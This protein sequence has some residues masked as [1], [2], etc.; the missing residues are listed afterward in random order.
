MDQARTVP[1]RRRAMYQVP[2]KGIEKYLPTPPMIPASLG[3]EL[4]LSMGA[5]DDQSWQAGQAHQRAGAAGI[6]SAHPGSRSLSVVSRDSGLQ[7]AGAA[8]SDRDIAPQK[9][10]TICRVAHPCTRSDRRRRNPSRLRRRGIPHSPPSSASRLCRGQAPSH[11]P[12][13]QPRRATSIC[14]T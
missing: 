4:P 9:R 14:A 2:G 6:F 3:K 8:I 13:T 1:S 10:V 12:P 7:S 11:P 5:E